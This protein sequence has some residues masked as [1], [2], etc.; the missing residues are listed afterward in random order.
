MV[1]EHITLVEPHFHD[2]QFGPRSIGGS[3]EPEAEAARS[4]RPPLGAF[5][6]LGLVLAGLAYRRFRT[7]GDDRGDGLEVDVE[8]VE[9]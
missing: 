2:A 9:A 1:F 7:R 6:L 8:A 5:V 3:A 4:Q